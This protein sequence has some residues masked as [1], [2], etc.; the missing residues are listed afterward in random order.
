MTSAGAFT[1]HQQGFPGDQRN[2]SPV[3]LSFSFGG[4]AAGVF[5]TKRQL[6]AALLSPFWDYRSQYKDGIGPDGRFKVQRTRRHRDER[7]ASST[8]HLDSDEDVR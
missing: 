3:L 5:P 8:L 4:K 2:H 7:V 1:G 6:N